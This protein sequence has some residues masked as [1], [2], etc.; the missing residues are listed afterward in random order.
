M[1]ATL[2]DLQIPMTLLA[3]ITA[4][5]KPKHLELPALAGKPRFRPPYTKLLP[6]QMQTGAC[7]CY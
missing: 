4:L 2:P 5:L 1:N 3:N 7:V 6:F